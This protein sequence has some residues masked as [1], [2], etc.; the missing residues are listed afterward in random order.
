MPFQLST[1]RSRSTLLTTGVIGLL[2]LASI[3]LGAQSIPESSGSGPISLEELANTPAIISSR[4]ESQIFNA[5]SGSFVFDEEDI[6]QLP[7]DSIPEMLRYAPGVHIVRPSNGI[8]GMG[9]R[10]VNSRFFNRALFTVDEQNVYASIFA[11]LFGSQHDLLMEDVASVEV[12]Y[13]PGGGTWDNN[14]VN[15]LVNVRMKTAFETEGTLLTAN[16]GTENRGVAA[17]IG[18]AIDD[19]TSARVYAK[20]N[21]RDSSLTRFPYGNDWDTART[22]FRVDHR[23]TNHDLV[24][25]SGEAFY[26]DLGYA[27]NL[28]DFETGSLDFVADSERL[29][30]A[31]TQIKWTRN[32]SNDSS[33]SVRSWFG[34]S[35]LDAAYAAFG[36][37]TAGIEARGRQKWGDAHTV[38]FNVGSAYDEEHTSS[39]LASDFT[40]PVLNSFVMYSGIQDEWVLSPEQLTLSWG[41]D[42]RHDDRSNNTTISPNASLI[43]EIDES[44]RAWLTYSQSNRNPPVS[45]SVIESLRSGKALDT[46]LDISTP[47]GTLTVEHSLADAMSNMLLDAEV[48]DSIEAGYRVLLLDEKG[49]FTLNAFHYGYDNLIGR[50]GVSNALVLDTPTPYVKINGAY[51]NLLKGD[52]Y[53]FE[54]SLDWQ[55][56]P[57]HRAR[58]N[59][60][61]KRDSFESIVTPENA[62]QEDFINFSIGEFD[63]STPDHMATLNLSSEI[64]DDWNLDTGL[65]YTSS[66][67]FA[68]GLQPEIFQLDARLTWQKTESLR[69]SLVGRNLL[70][71]TTQEA[72]LKDFFGHWT[73]VKREVYLE[74]SAQF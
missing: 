71:S 11:G 39:T 72:R 1:P 56:S 58:I 33:Y 46:P 70:D 51:D 19:K 12:A 15:G 45:L 16:V 2:A 64:S 52:A 5:P 20:A 8:W 13:G 7:V 68:K 31:N 54:T 22:G 42:F 49:S 38:S 6:A 34:Y 43:F 23:P 61:Y 41:V 29:A 67:N 40:S 55:F 18:W 66:Y 57:K 27:Y 32:V 60:S 74:I 10:G 4:L 47:G 36:M 14:A 73:E 62:F 53:G 44:S 65:R 25:V 3:E 28:A 30:G 9:I 17:R 21:I 48:M 59:Y 37:W 63:H 35:D 69:L 50:V 26:S 24:S